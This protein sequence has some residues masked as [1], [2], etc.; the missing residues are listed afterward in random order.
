M[1]LTDPPLTTL[2]VE[3]DVFLERGRQDS[4]KRDKTLDTF[5]TVR[6]QSGITAGTFF[7]VLKDSCLQ[8]GDVVIPRAHFFC[9]ARDACTPQNDVVPLK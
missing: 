5:F 4:G 9:M 6:D 7:G 2:Y 3:V 8:H 1:F